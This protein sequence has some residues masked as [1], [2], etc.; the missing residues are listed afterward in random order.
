MPVDGKQIDVGP[1]QALCIPRGANATAHALNQRPLGH[2]QTAD[3]FQV[4][5]GKIA[6]RQSAVIADQSLEAWISLREDRVN[7]NVSVQKMAATVD[8]L[9]NFTIS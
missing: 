2:V 8:R 3:I 9:S 7:I 5:L 6:S 4:V 1:G